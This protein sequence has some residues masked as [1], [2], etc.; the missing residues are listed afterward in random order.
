MKLTLKQLKH[1]IEEAIKLPDPS[2][3]SDEDIVRRAKEEDMRSQ[4]YLEDIHKGRG[5]ARFELPL[6]ARFDYT[7][8][9]LESIG[10]QLISDTE[11]RNLSRSMSY[12]GEP[13][14][15][16]VDLKKMIKDAYVLVDPDLPEGSREFNHY[17]QNRY[18]DK[19]GREILVVMASDEQTVVFKDMAG[20]P[21]GG[22]PKYFVYEV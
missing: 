22:E 12:T 17:V 2:Q 19:L 6:S 3:L 20:N 10:A 14:Q 21:A 9:Y 16:V 7:G 13:M 18:P 4:E 15:S 8:G 5:P 11:A 1:I